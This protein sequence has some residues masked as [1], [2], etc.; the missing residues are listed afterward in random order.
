MPI[1][2]R[3]ACCILPATA[4]MLLPALSHAAQQEPD[5][6]SSTDAMQ[7]GEQQGRSADRPAAGKAYL[8]HDPAVPPAP[9]PSLM[10]TASEQIAHD[11]SAP[12]TRQITSGNQSGAGVLQL[13]KADLDAT[14]AQLSAVERRVLLQAIEGSDICDAPPNVPAILALC[15]NRLETQAQEFSAAPER[16]VSAEERLLRGDL[17]NSQLPS[18]SQVIERLARGNAATNDFSNQVIASIALGPPS[19][20][21]SRPGDEDDAT[22]PSLGE[23]AQALINSLINQLTGG[24]P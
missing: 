6:T 1:R 14:L 15:Q 11:A 19:S 8:D 21:P 24:Q 20:Q 4:A 2:V 23:E 10:Q 16:V 18:L 7:I 22:N 17:E 3:L 12:P 9:H 5:R 13:S